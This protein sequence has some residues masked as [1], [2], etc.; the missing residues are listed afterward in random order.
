MWLNPQGNYGFVLLNT[1]KK[2]FVYYG[3]VNINHFEATG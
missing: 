1:E 3:A 2:L